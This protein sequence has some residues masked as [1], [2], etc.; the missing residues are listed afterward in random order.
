M[1]YRLQAYTAYHKGLQDG[2]ARAF[3]V[4]WCASTNVILLF[5][6][7]RRTPYLAEEW[8]GSKVVHR[9]EQLRTTFPWLD[10]QYIEAKDI[11]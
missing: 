9:R 5:R 6:H 10:L 4:S 2:P 3:T 11:A 8:A 1:G 7:R